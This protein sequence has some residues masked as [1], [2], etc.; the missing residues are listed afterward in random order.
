MRPN[1]IQDPKGEKLPVPMEPTEADIKEQDERTPKELLTARK[2]WDK[3][4]RQ[5][6]A[7]ARKQ[8]EN[9]LQKIAR[10]NSTK[11]ARADAVL[12]EL[13]AI[14]RDDLSTEQFNRFVD[15][16]IQ[17]GEYQEAYKLTGN[18]EYKAIW[19]VIKGKHKLCKCPDTEEWAM[20]E[21]KPVQN[22]HSRLF[23]RKKVWHIFD[24]KEVSLMMCNKCGALS[25]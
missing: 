7:V 24:Q 9:I 3:T 13:S 5:K 19:S 6:G 4:L 21:G 10:H 2:E 22:V 23:V 15:A 12:T 17:I 18:A 16:L 1:D 14:P 8:Q 20:V 25:A 11:F